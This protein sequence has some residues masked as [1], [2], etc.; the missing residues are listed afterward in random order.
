MGTHQHPVNVGCSYVSYTNDKSS[1]ES[2][3]WENGQEKTTGK[4]LT[5]TVRTIFY[6]KGREKE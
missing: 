6:K 5:V 3:Q 4:Y 2:H 1:T